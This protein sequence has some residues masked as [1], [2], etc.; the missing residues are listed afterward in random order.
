MSAYSLEKTE[1]IDKIF[2]RLMKK[3]K[4]QLEII[5]AKLEL[6]LDD[7]YRFKPLRSDMK[8]YREVHI[9]K[10][11]VLIY[12]IDELRKTVI[13]KDYNHHENIFA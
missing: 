8:S 6:I 13:L 5:C 1:E 12:S 10:H 4:K 9:D 3:N 2:S 7:P 11:F